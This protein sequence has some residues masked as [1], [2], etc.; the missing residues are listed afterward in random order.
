MFTHSLTYPNASS[1]SPL[2]SPSPSP[3]HR[4]R[5]RPTIPTMAS[6][7]ASRSASMTSARPTA[8]ANATRKYRTRSMTSSPSWANREENRARTVL[9]NQARTVRAKMVPG[10]LVVVMIIIHFCIDLVSRSS[11]LNACTHAVLY[12]SISLFNTTRTG[13]RLSD[14]RTP[15]ARRGRTPS[16]RWK[17]RRQIRRQIRRKVGQ[18][19]SPFVLGQRKG[20]FRL[21]LQCRRHH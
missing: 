17:I 11:L 21:R 6:T 5:D 20:I 2:P 15:R 12:F 14:G 18:G 13:Q 7:T 3:S 4:A 19:F 8:T 16:M 9:A 1:S 10:R